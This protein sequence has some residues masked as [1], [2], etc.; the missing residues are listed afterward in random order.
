MQTEL[1]GSV[2]IDIRRSAILS[3]AKNLGGAGEI[4]RSP[5]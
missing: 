3:K 5:P 2:L 1:P 4:L